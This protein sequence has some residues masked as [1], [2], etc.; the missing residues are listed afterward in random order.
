MSKFF[1]RSSVLMAVVAT[2]ALLGGLLAG[3]AAAHSSLIGSSP[4]NGAKVATAPDKVVLTFNEDLKSEYAVMKVIGPDN[5]FWQQG[6]PTVQG[7]QMSVALNGLGPAGKYDVNF[8]VTSADGHPIDGQVSFE[9][10]A[11]GTGTAGAQAEDNQSSDEGNGVAAWPFIIGGVVVILLVAG[12][13][14]M[15]L[16]KRRR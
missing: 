9:L 10:T 14:A 13:L 12:V 3:P 15:L 2:V 8:R 16:T 7:A 1:A 11:A 4:E 5:H 6:E